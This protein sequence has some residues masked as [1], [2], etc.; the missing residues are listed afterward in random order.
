MEE[1]NLK[2]TLAELGILPEEYEQIKGILGRE[3]NYTEL[4]I[5]SVM[6]SE[7]ASYKN[8]IKWIKTLPREGAC[9][10]VGAGEENAGLVDV[11]DGWGCAFKIESHNHPCAVEPYQGAA[12]GVGGINRDIFTMGAR[13]VAQLNSLHFGDLKNARTRWLLDGVVRTTVPPLAWRWQAARWYSTRATRRIP[14]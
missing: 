6:W 2:D 4:S 11:G 13:P 9:L 5:Y 10:L 8:S 14:W 7:H 12:T 1:L 3:P